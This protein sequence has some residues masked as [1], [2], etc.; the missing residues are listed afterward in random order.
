MDAAPA[1]LDP[2]DGT[3]LSVA[4]KPLPNGVYTV[5][6]RVLSAADGHVTTGAFPFAV[7]VTAIA[8]PAPAPSVSAESFSWGEALSRALLYLGAALLGAG[9]FL[10]LIWEPVARARSLNETAADREQRRRQALLNTSGYILAFGGSALGLLAKAGQ[11]SGAAGQATKSQGCRMR[12]C[13]HR[14]PAS[15]RV[16]CQPSGCQ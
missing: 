11:L 8:M 4:L 15:A 10:T 16:R 6:W 3:H 14:M 12:W 1:Q 9:L 7:G 2:A 13:E 5:S